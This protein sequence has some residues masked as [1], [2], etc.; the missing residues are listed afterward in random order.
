MRN[1]E[2]MFKDIMDIVS[3]KLNLHFEINKPEYSEYY[4]LP[5]WSDGVFVN[6]KITKRFEPTGFKQYCNF[7]V[8]AIKHFS[9]NNP[10][11]INVLFHE[12][13]H[14]IGHN[15]KQVTTTSGR[16]ANCRQ[17]VI[18]QI[19][20]FRSSEEFIAESFSMRIMEKLKL[21]TAETDAQSNA[22][23]GSNVPI[24]GLNVENLLQERLNYFN[25]NILKI[26]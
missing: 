3:I 8:I 23:L 22:Y 20:I 10:E 13:G 6:N 2:K 17:E 24:D 19:E 26:Y 5:W 15:L 25:E 21:N 16:K 9:S 1:N 18:D 12:I 7:D 4:H 11:T 14:A